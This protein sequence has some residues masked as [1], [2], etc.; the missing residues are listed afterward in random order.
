MKLILVG[1]RRFIG[2]W[3]KIWPTSPCYP[4][5]ARPGLRYPQEGSSVLC[6]RLFALKLRLCF[7]FPLQSALAVWEG[8]GIPAEMGSS[9]GIVAGTFGECGSEA[10]VQAWMRYNIFLLLEVGTFNALVELLN[11][12]IE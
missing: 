7:S 10:E 4:G 9:K 2:V 11:M 1:A 6:V 8:L 5:S 12:E 3:S